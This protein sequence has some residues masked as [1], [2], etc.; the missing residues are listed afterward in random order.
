MSSPENVGLDATWSAMDDRQGDDQQPHHVVE[1][2]IA[3]LIPPGWH[4]HEIG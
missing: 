3:E 1:E 2:D 4:D